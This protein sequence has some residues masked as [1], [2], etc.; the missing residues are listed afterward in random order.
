MGDKVRITRSRAL[1]AD[2]TLASRAFRIIAIGYDLNG[3]CTVSA[4]DDE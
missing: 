1:S 2:G 4:I 3:D